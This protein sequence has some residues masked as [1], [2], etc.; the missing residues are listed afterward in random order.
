MFDRVQ[1]W[2]GGE[3]PAGED[4]FDLALKRDFVHLNECISI[5]RFGR[6]ARVAHP[7]SHLQRAELHRFA[8]RRI[9]TDNAAR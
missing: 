2:T 8:N 6:R 7:R 4:A 3:H 9:E 1:A 5:G